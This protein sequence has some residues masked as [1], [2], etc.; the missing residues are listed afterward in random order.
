MEGRRASG[1]VNNN[2]TCGEQA[3]VRKSKACTHEVDLDFL[4]S[5]LGLVTDRQRSDDLSTL[6]PQ[7]VNQHV[8][9][10]PLGRSVETVSDGGSVSSSGSLNLGDDLLIGVVEALGSAE[11]AE[12]FMVGR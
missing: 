1:Q 9:A 2:A 5:V 11:G 8:R 10:T 12:E 6:L 3:S 7:A 4:P